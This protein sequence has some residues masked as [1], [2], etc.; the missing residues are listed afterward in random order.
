MKSE[1]GWVRLNERTVG[2]PAY[3]HKL[4]GNYIARGAWDNFRCSTVLDR[5]IAEPGNLTNWL[6]CLLGIAVGLDAT[7]ERK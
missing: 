5:E 3:D 2:W 1:Q 6:K 7:S 4:A